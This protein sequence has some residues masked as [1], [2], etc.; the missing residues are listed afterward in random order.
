M[1]TSLAETSFT[2]HREPL[3]ERS[4]NKLLASLPP[5]DY[6]RIAPHLRHVPMMAKQ[7]LYKQDMPISSV[8]FPGGGACSLVKSTEDGQTAEI[9]VI[10]AEGVIGA[11]AFFG[12]HHAPCDVIVQIAGP[13]AQIMPAQLFITEMERHG[14]LY[15]RIVRYSQAL[16]AQVMQSTVCNGLH[17]AQQRCVRWLLA[18]RDRAATNEFP[19]THE[20]LATMLG[21]RRPTV[22]LI[23]GQLR[24]AGLI[25]HRRGVVT[26]LDRDGL[27]AVACECY[28]AVRLTFDRLLPELKTTA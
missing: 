10:G 19:F 11:S 2:H 25:H 22:T 15:N 16:M 7:T 1:T 9:A 28:R 13:G 20:F 12:L 27:E 3:T 24:S 21:V 26:I 14:P 17:S 5:E 4:S 18:T 23:I 6:E 8:Y